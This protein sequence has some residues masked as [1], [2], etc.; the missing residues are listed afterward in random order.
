MLPCSGLHPPSSALPALL[1]PVHFKS[2][3]LLAMLNAAAQHQRLPNHPT[4]PLHFFTR[5][6]L[7]LPPR[8]T[9]FPRPLLLCPCAG[10]TQSPPPWPTSRSPTQ[11]VPCQPRTL[12]TAPVSLTAAPAGLPDEPRTCAWHVCDGHIPATCQGWRLGAVPSIQINCASGTQPMVTLQSLCSRTLLCLGASSL[13]CPPG[14]NTI[15]WACKAVAPGDSMAEGCGFW[16]MQYQ[17]YF[18][19]DAVSE[20]K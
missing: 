6:H 5:V 16:K 17:E 10:I 8:G 18:I 12:T 3:L 4:P 9:P 14:P 15:P 11:S 13:C 1:P 19:P 7:Q 2:S 20:V